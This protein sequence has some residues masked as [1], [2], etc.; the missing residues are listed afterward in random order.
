[1]TE[2]NTEKKEWL[3]FNEEFSTAFLSILKMT[4]SNTDKKKWLNFVER[5]ITTFFLI[6]NMT[7]SNR[8]ENTALILMKYLLPHSF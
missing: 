5:F 3:N 4:K 2:S 8:V 1:M 7:K 6:L